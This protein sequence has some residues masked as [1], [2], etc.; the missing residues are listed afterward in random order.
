MSA[1]V[2]G[3][4][5]RDALR[6]RH[7]VRLISSD[8]EGTA[9]GELPAGVYGFTGSPVLASPM[10]SAYRYRN[11]E[12]HRLAAGPAVVGFAAPEDAARLAVESTAPVEVHLHPDRDE[13]ATEIVAIPYDRIVQHRQYSIRNAGAITL[14][15][16]PTSALSAV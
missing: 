13:H 10:F 15:V 9:A 11:F 7:N 3:E 14:Q 12:V 4:Q 6:K 2:S 8:H 16:L 5:A 1:N